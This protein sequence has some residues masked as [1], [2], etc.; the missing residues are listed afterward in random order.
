MRRFI[1]LILFLFF[2]SC[3]ESAPQGVYGCFVR[4][5]ND[6]DAEDLVG[7]LWFPSWDG[8]SPDEVESRRREL[9]PTAEREFFLD[10]IVEHEVI[11]V[12]ELADG[13][14]RILIRQVFLDPYGNRYSDRYYLTIVRRW[15]D[16]FILVPGE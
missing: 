1:P 11:Q 9:I 15:D 8:L 6:R 10:R 12:E 2:C 5:N 3:G 14:R 16:W 4:A 7:C 13:E